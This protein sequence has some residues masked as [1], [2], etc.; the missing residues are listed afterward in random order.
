MSVRVISGTADSCVDLWLGNADG[1]VVQF[2]D[3]K[4]LNKENDFTVHKAHIKQLAK[5]CMK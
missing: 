2:I 1:T 4:E 5:V 3:F